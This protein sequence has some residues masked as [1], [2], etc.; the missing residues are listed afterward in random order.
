V[1]DT[2]FEFAVRDGKG[3]ATVVVRGDLDAYT[4]PRFS[5]CLR[6]A[7]ADAAGDVAIDMAEV[8]FVDSSGIAILVA[9]AKQLRERGNVLVIQSPPRMV[10]KVL[11]MTGVTKL[12]KVER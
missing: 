4:G 3:R 11:E 12:V 1:G 7:V 2:N 9:S 8:S 5:E 6:G 10:G